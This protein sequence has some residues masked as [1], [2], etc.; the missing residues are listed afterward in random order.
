MA[1][2]PS[3]LRTNTMRIYE[4]F[5]G[6]AVLANVLLAAPG[7]IM[8]QN[9]PKQDAQNAGHETKEAAKD[10]GKA[11]KGA[12]QKTGHAV[13]KGTHKAATKTEEGADKVKNKTGSQ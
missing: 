6:V 2:K 11:A 13:K 5:A 7:F 10:T 4:R 3:E 12:V 9:S 1:V 8:A